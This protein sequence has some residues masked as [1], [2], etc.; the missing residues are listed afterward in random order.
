MTTPTTQTIDVTSSG[1][2]AGANF[3]PAVKAHVENL[4]GRAPLLLTSVGGTAS[5]VTATA[6]PVPPA[7]IDG[8]RFLLVPTVSI[9]P[10]ATL[11]IGAFAAG[12]I[13][14]A[15]GA[16][17]TLPIA[18]GSVCE[19]VRLDGNYRLI[20]GGATATAPE[21][22]AEIQAAAV[23]VAAVSVPALP[24]VL[25]GLPPVALFS[26][27]SG[28][29]MSGGAYCTVGDLLT[30]ST[31]PKRVIGP[32]G[33]L[34]TV[35]ANSPAW[36]WSSGR[37][38]LVV[39]AV[40]ATK[41]GPYSESLSN[42]AWNKIGVT[43][44]SAIAG[45]DGVA[46]LTP[47]I[48]DSSDG[49]HRL[50]VGN[51]GATVAAAGENWATQVVV[52][53]VSGA[54]N[55]RLQLAGSA[56][57]GSHY[58]TVDLTTGGILA[59]AGLGFVRISSLAD[60]CWRIE[61]TAASDAAG[62]IG[63]LIYGV[64]ETSIYYVGDSAATWAV[65]YVNT[66]RVTGAAEPPS[67]Y[68]TVS[69]SSSVTRVADDVRVSSALAA[70][71][72]G[73]YTIAFRASATYATSL[74]RLIAFTSGFALGWYTSATT[75]RSYDGVQ[76]LVATLG[77]S[78]VTAFGAAMSAGV[79]SWLLCGNGGEVQSR[80]NPGVGILTAGVARLFAT[81]SGAYATNGAVDE[82]VV[83]PFVASA[84]GLMAQARPWS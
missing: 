79:G 7:L 4:H 80:S 77:S 83:W 58:V 61:V 29:M 54:R 40:A 2:K 41:Y 5:A 50:A 53:R 65:G 67:S 38:R 46:G 69:G 18:A 52:K 57:S 63:V 51:V 42:A 55:V 66:E 37:R 33:T 27:P 76:S 60:S 22:L 16:Y 44:G 31:A 17:L 56:F 20:A 9:I 68:V 15:A 45:P 43:T 32:T 48:E 75:I 39:E 35:G 1:G 12:Y 36:D 62:I 3:L 30:F 49:P 26:A 47:F 73:G 10:G 82:I 11:V 24:H 6:S 21:I 34:D 28:A 81:P 71:F 25:D 19:L 13:L 72:A 8:M 64:S 14:D 84:G 70:R 23:S 78:A 59:Q 74:Q